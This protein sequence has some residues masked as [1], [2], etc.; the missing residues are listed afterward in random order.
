MMTPNVSRDDYEYK[1]YD[2]EE[3]E[4]E[5]IKGN[6]TNSKSSEEDDEEIEREGNQTII[7]PP[8]VRIDYDNGDDR[9]DCRI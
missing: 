4:P 8:T 1:E 2:Y 7:V 5:I 9:N 6:G 3:I